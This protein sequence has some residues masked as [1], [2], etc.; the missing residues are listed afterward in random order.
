MKTKRNNHKELLHAK[1]HL[2][3][4]EKYFIK[5]DKLAAMGKAE[6]LFAKSIIIK[7]LKKELLR[8]RKDDKVSEDFNK[9]VNKTLEEE[10]G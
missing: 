10:N 6:F 3:M 4:C 7:Q 9:E 8:N 5:S 2:D 1:D